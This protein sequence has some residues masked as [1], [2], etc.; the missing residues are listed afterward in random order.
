MKKALSQPARAFILL[1]E[2]PCGSCVG[3]RSTAVSF[4]T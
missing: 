1:P 2:Q 3:G 4:E